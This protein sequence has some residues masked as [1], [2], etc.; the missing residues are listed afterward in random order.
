MVEI[1]EIQEQ[2]FPIN[3]NGTMVNVKFCIAELP[4]DMKMLGIPCRVSNKIF[5]CRVGSLTKY[6][7]T[8]ANVS[9][10]DC[11]N[12]SGSF[13]EEKSNTW[14]PWKY[15]ERLAVAKAVD[16]LKKKV[17]KQS[18]KPSSKHNKITSFIVQKSSHQEFVPLVGKLIDQAHVDPPHLK[19]NACALAHR[20]LLNEII[21][22]S[23][24]ESITSFSQVLASSPFGRYIYTMCN[25]TRLA[26]QIVRWFNETKAEG[27]QFDYRFTGKDSRL[28][29]QNFMFLI[30][31]VE[32]DVKKVSREE[33]ILHVLA[34][35]CLCLRDS[36]SIFTCV[37]K[38]HCSNYYKAHCIILNVNPTVWTLGNVV[39]NHIE[40]MKTRYG[41]GLGL[42][43]MEGR[44]AKHVFIAKY[45]K[46]TLYQCRW[47]QIFRP[48]YVTLI[49]L[50]S[51]GLN[52]SKPENNNATYILKKVFTDNTVCYCG[53]PKLAAANKCSFCS[54]S[55]RGEVENSIMRGKNM[56]S[57]GTIECK[58]C[59]K[60][61][62]KV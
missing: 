42:N 4:N 18:I 24:L 26:K 15:S 27:K 39:P 61:E 45:S 41:M 12:T 46:N 25:L 37:V 17:D 14:R 6:F 59:G 33:L 9:L 49:W 13:G 51:R 60:G 50:C 3:V 56:I 11:K 44:E 29:L 38:Q 10:D 52:V 16:L 36:I 23:H 20:Y 8:F 43:S 47:Q 19:K 40:D 22:I 2:V 53:L 55:L 35:I 21:S 34:Y 32:N 28:F 1:A 54:H 62:V 58:T 5:I 7:S 57:G 48:E 31:C 30:S